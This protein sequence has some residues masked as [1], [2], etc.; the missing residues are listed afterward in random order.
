MWLVFIDLVVIIMIGIVEVVG[1]CVSVC[2]VWKLFMFGMIMFMIIRL[3]RLVCMCFM[4]F[5]VVFMVDM[6]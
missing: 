1:L 5:L 2:V 6:E 3:G 4:F